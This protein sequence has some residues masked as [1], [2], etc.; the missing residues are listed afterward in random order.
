M[1]VLSQTKKE[2]IFFLTLLI[3]RLCAPPG[4]VAYTPTGSW[5]S[6]TPIMVPEFTDFHGNHL[7]TDLMEI[8]RC[9]PLSLPGGGSPGGEPLDLVF[10]WF[11]PP[12][13]QSSPPRPCSTGRAPTR[14][15]APVAPS[16]L[17]TILSGFLQSNFFTFLP[18]T[19]GKGSIEKKEH[20]IVIVPDDDNTGPGPA[21]IPGILMMIS[22]GLS[23]SMSLP[24]HTAFLHPEKAG[25]TSPQRPQFMLSDERSWHRSSMQSFCPSGHTMLMFRH[26]AS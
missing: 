5:G 4:A 10:D 26:R 25:Q 7:N 17:N 20:C 12:G 2:R 6:L 11:F 1:A 14:R 16:L 21:L 24:S 18:W 15:R 13:C 8:A 3:H 19:M 9:H 23:D 22:G